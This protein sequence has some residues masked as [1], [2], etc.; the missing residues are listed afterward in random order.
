MES[1]KIRGYIFLELL[2]AVFH[3]LPSLFVRAIAIEPDASLAFVLPA[4]N[5]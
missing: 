2:L 3:L 5:W 1:C 4:S